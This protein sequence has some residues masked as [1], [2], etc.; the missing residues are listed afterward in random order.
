MKLIFDANDIGYDSKGLFEVDIDCMNVKSA[1]RRRFIAM[2]EQAP[3]M[4][5]ALKA[6]RLAFRVGTPSNINLD[7]LIERA[8]GGLPVT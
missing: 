1:D 8:E 7:E 2:I 4:L 3:D 5:S 6:I